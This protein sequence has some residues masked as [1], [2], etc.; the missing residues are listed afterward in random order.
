MDTPYWLE[1]EEALTHALS[2]IHTRSRLCRLEAGKQDLEL[3]NLGLFDEVLSSSRLLNYNNN[4]LQVSEEIKTRIFELTDANIAH[5]QVGF[6]RAM[7]C[8]VGMAVGDSLGHNFE[9]LPVQDSACEDGPIFEFPSKFG[10]VVG[11]DRGRF[12]KALNRFDLKPGQWTDDT[13][14]GLCMADSLLTRGAFDG[15]NM[16]IWFWNWWHNG[17]NNGFRFDHELMATETGSLSVGLGSNIAKSL[18]DVDDKARLGQPIT[19]AFE[20]DSDDAGNGSLMRLGPIAV[21]YHHDLPECMERA[22]ASSRTTHPGRLA[23]DA[24]AFLAFLLARAL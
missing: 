8:L 3:Q 19:P 9:F 21:R 12:H 6:S 11:H 23:A 2:R 13:S 16:R 5:G 24:C 20:S 1:L 15:S 10:C 22:R 17:L 18:A 7:G 4:V 14:M